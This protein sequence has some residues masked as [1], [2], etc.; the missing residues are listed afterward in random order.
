MAIALQKE[1]TNHRTKTNKSHKAQMNIMKI[2]KGE[3]S[4]TL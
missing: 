1:E 4:M 2:S 3:D